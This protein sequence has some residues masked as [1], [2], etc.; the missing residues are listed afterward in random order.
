MI[1]KRWAEQAARQFNRNMVSYLPETQ[2]KLSPVNQQLSL[3]KSVAKDP[4]YFS[5][6]GRKPCGCGK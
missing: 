5:N 4:N 2:K 6:K 3:N 1:N